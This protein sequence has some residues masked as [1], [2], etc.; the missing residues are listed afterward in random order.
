MLSSVNS[1]Y[2]FKYIIIG[3]PSVGKSQILLRYVND[4]FNEKYQNTIGLEFGAK[5]LN[6]NNTLYRIQIWD[7][8]G[9][10]K[11]KSI[12]RGYYKNSVCALI[13]YDISKKQSFDN[14]YKWMEDCKNQSSKTI[15]MALIGNKI[16]LDH[17]R[18]VN[19]EEGKDFADKYNMLFF[20]TSAKTGFNIDKVFFDT[21]SKIIQSLENG[22]YDLEDENCGI[23]I[24]V[25]S[26]KLKI[27]NNKN[28]NNDGDEEIIIEKNKCC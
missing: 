14:I 22:F 7:T 27:I 21:A 10:E 26:K 13:V 23:K 12:I 15:L 6:I 5:N 4:I 8:A 2:I 1:D 25:T 20:E 18:E 28:D 17:K 16:D 3:D 11:Y 19:Y 24:S 9:Q